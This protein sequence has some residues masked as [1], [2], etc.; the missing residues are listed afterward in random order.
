MTP[1]D[2]LGLLIKELS[3][4]GGVE[5]NAKTAADP[6]KPNVTPRQAISGIFWKQLAL[7]DLANRP[8]DPHT[9]DD[10]LGHILSM[11]LEVLQNQ[12]LLAQLCEQFG[13][14]VAKTLK[15][16]KESFNARA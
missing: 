6:N 13:I 1:N 16:V 3:A 11:R 14:N 2:L 4:S 15:E 9:T 7:V 12:A 10:Q 5:I 8:R